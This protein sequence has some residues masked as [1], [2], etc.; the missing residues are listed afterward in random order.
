M[1]AAV[2]KPIRIDDGG[3]EETLTNADERPTARMS[4]TIRS[5]AGGSIAHR[6]SSVDSMAAKFMVAGQLRARA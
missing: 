5:I 1:R 6:W 4:S 2:A 3:C